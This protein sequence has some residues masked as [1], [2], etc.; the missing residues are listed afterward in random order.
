[1]NYRILL[2][3]LITALAETACTAVRSDSAQQTEVLPAVS[4]TP[5]AAVAEPTTAI[6]EQD[7]EGT[8]MQAVEP[9]PTQAPA[10]AKA[11]P[12][13]VIGPAPAWEN[14]VWI[15]SDGPL[16]LEALRGKVVLLEFWTFG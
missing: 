4:A 3:I 10:L 8:E 12:L 9:E 16:P 14:E 1:M 7:V 6:L 11:S 13:P 2:L 15:N 5:Q